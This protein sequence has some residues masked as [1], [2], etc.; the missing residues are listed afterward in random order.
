MGPP[1]EQPVARFI[2]K[3]WT[4]PWLMRFWPR[5]RRCMLVSA[6]QQGCPRSLSLSIMWILLGVIS[7][8]RTFID[9]LCSHDW[10]LVFACSGTFAW[11]S[12]DCTVTR[13]EKNNTCLLIFHIYLSFP[14]KSTA[15]S[16]PSGRRSK[17]LGVGR[18]PR[19]VIH[20]PVGAQALALH[21]D[22]G[23]VMPS[24]L[25]HLLTCGETNVHIYTYSLY[26]Y[27]YTWSIYIY[28]IK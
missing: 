8:N 16:P 26:I 27:I 28:D 17:R 3:G 2:L 13:N 6:F 9:P 23:Q 11:P 24:Q 22:V 7:S 12:A 15:T 19:A 10:G 4:E 25:D 21:Q 20:G 14:T 1:S 18:W 5:L